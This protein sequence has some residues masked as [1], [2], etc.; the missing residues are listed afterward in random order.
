MYSL[1]IVAK[2]DLELHQ[3]EVKT[4]F[5]NRELKE[6]IYMIQ[7]EGF[8]VEGHVEKVYKFNYKIPILA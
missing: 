2:I 3:L 1:N 7:N 8:Q 4:T 6:N 5:L